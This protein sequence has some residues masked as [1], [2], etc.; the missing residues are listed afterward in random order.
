MTS[1][2]SSMSRLQWSMRFLDLLAGTGQTQ[3]MRMP[4]PGQPQ[5][6][7]TL[8]LPNLHNQPTQNP[9]CQPTL[10]LSNLHCPPTSLVEDTSMVPVHSSHTSRISKPNNLL[11][12]AGGLWGTITDFIDKHHSSQQYAHMLSL[13]FY[14]IFE[15]IYVTFFT[16]TMHFCL[17]DICIIK[18][19]KCIK[20]R[21]TV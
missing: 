16:P 4:N 15:N 1:G 17:H 14:L 7:Q 5:P 9:H 13:E 20:R 3:V 12:M 10:N 8:N 21:N 6:Q 19:R 2:L 18:A 11:D